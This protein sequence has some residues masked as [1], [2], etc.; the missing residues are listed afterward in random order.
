MSTCQLLYIGKWVLCSALK[1]GPK[2]GRGLC[3]WQCWTSPRLVLPQ[4]F[5]EHILDTDLIL[6][7][8]KIPSEHI[9]MRDQVSDCTD[10]A[11]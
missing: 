6:R 4:P 3:S 7:N 2:F 10:E 8:H 5:I 1:S 11:L 9:G